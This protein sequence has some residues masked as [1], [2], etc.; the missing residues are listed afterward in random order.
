MGNSLIRFLIK[1]V[2]LIRNLLTNKDANALSFPELSEQ[3]KSLRLRYTQ[4]Q[5]REQLHIKARET[6]DSARNFIDSSSV[7]LVNGL[8]YY[9]VD[10][11]IMST[12]YGIFLESVKEY[13]EDKRYFFQNYAVLI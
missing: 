3:I 9:H 7:D 12:L 11:D 6:I 8:T 1:K 13:N 10:G 2:I 4:E 5:L